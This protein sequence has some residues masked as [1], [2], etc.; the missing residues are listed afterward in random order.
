MLKNKRPTTWFALPALLMLFA[1]TLISCLLFLLFRYGLSQLDVVPTPTASRS[2]VSATLPLREL[3]RSRNILLRLQFGPPLLSTTEGTVFFV[4]H[5][6]GWLKARLQALDASTGQ[7]RWQTDDD[8]S[9]E[10]SLAASQGRLF[11]AVNWNIRAYDLSSGKPL[12]R[13][14]G[15]LPEHTG[16]EVYPVGDK[17]TVYST[18]DSQSKSLDVFS[19]YNPATGELLEQAKIETTE[20]R[21]LWR[22]AQVDYRDDCKY[23]SAVDRSSGRIIW[24]IAVKDCVSFWPDSVDSEKVFST[25]AGELFAADIAA[26]EV[27]WRYPKKCYS[28]SAVMGG[29]VYTIRADGILVGINQ[30]TGNEVGTIEFSPVGKGDG[31]PTYWVATDGKRLFAYFGDSQELIA[32]QP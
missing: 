31:I 32:F 2:I 5:S 25:V 27:L 26:G 11:I 21:L 18:M 24:K 20:A 3:W 17:L 29:I 14:P 30:K 4:N 13:T 28:N 19:V 8:V 15:R 1:I 7:L 10:H 22:T 16:Y 9:T 23:L 12:W 6:Q